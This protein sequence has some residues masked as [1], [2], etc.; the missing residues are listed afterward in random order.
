MIRAK[1]AVVLAASMWLCAFASS[2]RGAIETARPGP[3]PPIAMFAPARDCLA[4]HNN[5]VTPGGEDVSIGA[6]WRG[7]MMANSAR[8][9]YVQA[10][11]RRETIDH[12]SSAAA[13]EDE[14]AACHMPAA[15][16]TAHATGGK[17]KFFAHLA[18][19]ANG[20]RM[21]LDEVALDGVSCTICHQIAADRL[22][23]S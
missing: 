22:G 9:P 1:S 17:A 23:T 4:C 13:I 7:T 6:S 8:D 21:P 20:A 5:L 10:S 18:R 12:A 16:Q 15:R 19:P 11:V 3:R 14:C 2:P